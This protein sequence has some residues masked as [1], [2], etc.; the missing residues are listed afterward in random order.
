MAATRVLVL[1][2]DQVHNTKIE[3][4]LRETPDLHIEFFQSSDQVIDVL[5]NKST[6]L[7]KYKE[8]ERAI[9]SGQV[10]QAKVEE[11]ILK[12]DKQLIEKS[13]QLKVLIQ[14]QAQKAIVTSIEKSI[15]D[16]EAQMTKCYELKARLEKFM[17]QKKMA[18]ETSKKIVPTAP[19][20]KVH[21]ILI[22]RSFL[23]NI[24]SNW[25]EQ[26]RAKIS[27]AENKEAPIAVLGYNENLDYIQQ[28]LEGGVI[29]YFVKPIDLL[30]FKHNTSMLSGKPLDST[31]KVYEIKTKADIKMLKKV[32]V[33]SVSEFELSTQT[34]FTF[35]NNEICEFYADQFS[36]D[37]SGRLLG[38]CLEC[39]ADST[40]KGAYLSKFSLVGLSSSR[41]NEM[42]KW[43]IAQY[44]AIKAK[45][46]DS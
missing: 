43:L 8:L 4:A 26:F 34:N 13:A 42:R 32:L 1:D 7:E 31:N 30:L 28:T 44:V 20:Q 22:D 19:K 6:E 9:E 38:R 25:I 45:E 24:P 23:G 21:L 10:M 12:S 27:F 14:D 41:L 33:L 37:K 5:N 35:L 40:K 3:F 39:L 18:L 16:L 29:D 15:K 36:A 2:V 17:V 11:T 46:R